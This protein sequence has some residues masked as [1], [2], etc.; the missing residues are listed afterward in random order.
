[1]LTNEELE[2]HEKKQDL[3]D[4]HQATIQDIIYH[5]VDK[6]TFLQIKGEKTADMVCVR[7]TPTIC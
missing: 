2:K 6:S 3:Y 1:P 5:T 7:A 4:Q